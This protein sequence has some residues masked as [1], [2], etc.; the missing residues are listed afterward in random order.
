MWALLVSPTSEGHKAGQAAS[1]G[2]SEPSAARHP[3][4]SQE[5]EESDALTLG[6]QFKRVP[7][8]RHFTA[9]SHIIT[10]NA[11]ICDEQTPLK[12]LHKAGSVV[13]V[14]PFAWVQCGLHGALLPAL[15]KGRLVL[16]GTS[17]SPTPGEKES[18]FRT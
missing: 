17:G 16:R 6:A 12:S 4:Q 3:C 11:S 10:M 13:P 5:G 14:S 8:R 2:R 15:G 1:S 9:K 18:R 7:N